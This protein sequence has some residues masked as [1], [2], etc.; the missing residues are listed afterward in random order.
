MVRSADTARSWAPEPG[1]PGAPCLSVVVPCY[2]EEPVLRAFHQRMAAACAATGRDFEIVLVDD[3]SRDGT[4]AVIEEIAAA[5]G[6]VGVR[7]FRNFGHQAAVTAGLSVCR[8]S[9]VLIIDADLQDPPELLGPMMAMMDRGA[10]VVYGRRTRREGETLFKRATA[11]LFYRLLGWLS[12]TTIP[13]DTGDFRLMRR[14]VVDALL[15]MPEQQR[16]IRGMVSWIGGV[17]VPIDYE[18]KARAAGE[19]KYPLLKMLQ[20]ATDAV[21]SF[22][23]RPLRVATWTAMVFGVLSMGLLGYGLFRWWTDGTVPGWTSL[24]ATISF[25]SSIQFLMLGIIGEYVGRLV[26]EVKGR[27]LYMIDH[28]VS[29]DVRVHP[30]VNLST[31]PMQERQAAVSRLH[32]GLA[33]RAAT[34]MET[35]P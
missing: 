8:G 23:T 35:R 6:A 21:T 24:I 2:N 29:G 9:R 13:R 11:S 15:A 1:E 18:R 26:V 27:P 14:P 34:D 10:D 31:M 22:S 30:P 28:L 32:A 3:G 20:F 25:F 7:L 4:G 5:G 33:L 16:F 17:Q 19:T 12:T